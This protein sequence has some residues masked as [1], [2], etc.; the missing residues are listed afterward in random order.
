MI[1]EIVSKVCSLFLIIG[2]GAATAKCG[3]L[4][5]GSIPTLNKL[6]FNVMTPAVVFTTMQGQT[7]DGAVG[8]RH[9]LVFY[10]LYPGD[11]SHGNTFL[12]AHRGAPGSGAGPGDLQNA[13]G[14]QEH[15]VHGNPSGGGAGR[16]VGAGDSADECPLYDPNLLIRCP[17][18][19]LSEGGEPAEPRAA[20]ADAEC[21][22]GELPRGGG[23]PGGGMVATEGGQQQFENDLQRHGSLGHANRG[24]SAQQ[25]TC[26]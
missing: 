6:L 19:A 13:A 20:E 4:S 14:V 5:E 23:D 18:D 8:P 2:I 16:E 25:D 9:S 3:L 22:S 21:A 12:P 17:P 10:I 11:A 7:F 24:H 15:R 1:V 26:L